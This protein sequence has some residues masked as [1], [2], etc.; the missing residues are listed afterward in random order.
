MSYG[1]VKTYALSGRKML[2]DRTAGAPL[3]DA[4]DSANGMQLP[5]GGPGIARLGRCG[6]LCGVS[7][8]VLRPVPT[9]FDVPRG[10]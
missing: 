5:I 10:R 8:G 3:M 6:E 4:A 9:K 2:I 1:M 7:W